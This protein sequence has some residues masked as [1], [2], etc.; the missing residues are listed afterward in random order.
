MTGNGRST[1]HSRRVITLRPGVLIEISF[2]FINS[3]SPNKSIHYFRDWGRR[4]SQV[5]FP[6][7]HLREIFELSFFS[8]NVPTWSLDSYPK[9]D[10]N[11][12]SR[13]SEISKFEAH[14][15]CTYYTR[16]NIIFLAALGSSRAHAY[17]FWSSFPLKLA[18]KIVLLK[19]LVYFNALRNKAAPLQNTGIENA[20]TKNII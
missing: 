2:L 1:W 15:I 13:F 18:K 16:M 19:Y 14:I 9:F 3:S 5:R 11:I 10:S 17:C 20:F 4:Y 6:A 12:N 8:S 7:T